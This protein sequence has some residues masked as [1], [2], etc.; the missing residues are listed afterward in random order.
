M[1]QWI[2]LLIE[3]AL[4]NMFPNGNIRRID[5]ELFMG[6]IKIKTIFL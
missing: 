4:S 2:V 6:I 3:L 1:V 5:L